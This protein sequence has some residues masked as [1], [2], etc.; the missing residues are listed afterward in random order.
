MYLKCF[1]VLFILFIG[2]CLQSKIIIFLQK[3]ILLYINQFN[4]EWNNSIYDGQ[5]YELIYVEYYVLNFLFFY[6]FYLKWNFNVI[7]R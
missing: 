1:I 2:N 5:N 6:Y 3:L 7:E 4:L